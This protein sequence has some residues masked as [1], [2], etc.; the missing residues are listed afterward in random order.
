MS[1]FCKS[2]NKTKDSEDLGI[3]ED[4]TQYK[5]CVRCRDKDKKQ[6][7]LATKK[8]N[9]ARRGLNYCEECD[10]AKPRDKFVMPNGELYDKCCRSCLIYD[11]DDED[12]SS[13]NY[14]YQCVYESSIQPD[15][16]N[17]MKMD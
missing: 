3:K 1:V 15:C 7:K 10:K 8:A 17:L 13:S 9:A 16:N 12:D 2:C 11:S 14:S 5:T 4:E 6:Y